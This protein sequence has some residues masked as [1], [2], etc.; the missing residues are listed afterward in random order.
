M[1]AADFIK[2][3]EDGSTVV[4][5][6]YPFD[7]KDGQ[8]TEVKL[9]RPTVADLESADRTAGDLAKSISIIAS[10]S[11]LSV[12]SIKKMDAADF[13]KLSKV[14]EGYVGGKE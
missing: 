11:G 1:A 3:Q 5:L 13:G 9:R 2:V 10:V 14:V 6:E 7:A 4:T 8:V 12:A